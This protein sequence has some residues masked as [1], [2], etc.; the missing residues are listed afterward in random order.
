[1]LII[2]NLVITQRLKSSVLDVKRKY[3]SAQ[4]QAS[5]SLRLQ[6]VQLENEALLG[7]LEI[8]SAGKTKP[9]INPEVLELMKTSIDSGKILKLKNLALKEKRKFNQDLAQLIIAL[10]EVK[11]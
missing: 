10:K 11:I 9:L 3:Q 5:T 8:K 1:M 6:T 7:N 2:I 4:V